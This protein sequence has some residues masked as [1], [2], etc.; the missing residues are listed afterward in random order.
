M[1]HTEKNPTQFSLKF[2]S[3]ALE[4]SL[5]R[6]GHEADGP[7]CQ[8]L[9]GRGSEFN[10]PSQ[11]PSQDIGSREHWDQPYAGQVFPF[12]TAVQVEMPWA[13]SRCW[14]WRQQPPRQTESI[15][16]TWLS[17]YQP[18]QVAI[19]FHLVPTLPLTQNHW[20]S[21]LKTPVPEACLGASYSKGLGADWLSAL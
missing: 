3:F 17:R 2:T 9:H 5:V 21:L 8:V 18:T 6:T 20:C 15:A 11:E 16:S 12:V 7:S 10:L 13:S 19:S 4:G 14:A 1:Q